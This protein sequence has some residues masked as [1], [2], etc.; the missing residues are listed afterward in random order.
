[1]TGIRRS[2][3]VSAVVF[4][5]AA[6]RPPAASAQRLDLSVSPPVVSFAAANPDTVPTVSSSPIQVLYRVQQNVGRPW[7]LTIVA[8]G[9]LLSGAATVDIAQVG[10]S[11]TPSPPFRNGTLTKTVAQVLASGT[12]NANPV[13]TGTITFGL[14]NLWTY[15][16]GNYTQTVFFTLTAP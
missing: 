12:G 16:A 7:T 13:Q 10:W 1:V 5:A 11:A 6:V 9:D 8:G 15:S 2:I 4:A 3:A 14:K